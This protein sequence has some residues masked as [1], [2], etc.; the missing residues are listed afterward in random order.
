LTFALTGRCI[1]SIKMVSPS[2]FIQIQDGGGNSVE[3]PGKAHFLF[4]PIFQ[5]GVDNPAIFLLR[6]RSSIKP[7]SAV[8]NPCRKRTRLLT[9]TVEW[10]GRQT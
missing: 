8:P 6:R 9:T 2:F 7:A 1:N 10:I 4:D 3:G 5:G